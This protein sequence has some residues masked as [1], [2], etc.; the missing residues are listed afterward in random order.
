MASLRHRLLGIA[1]IMH[2]AVYKE[3]KKNHPGAGAFLALLGGEK[4][5]GLSCKHKIDKVLPFIGTAQ[6]IQ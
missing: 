4:F 3:V 6:I 2:S 1:Y 5:P